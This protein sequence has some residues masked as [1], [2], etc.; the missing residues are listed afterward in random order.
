MTARAL[1]FAPSPGQRPRLF[2]FHHAGGAASVFAAWRAA[3]AADLDVLP[4]QLPGRESR[5][6]EPL[7][8]DLGS[9]VTT[10][11]A[12][13]GPHLRPP[14]ALYGH[15]L[16][17][18]VAY[19]LARRRLSQG[20]APPT[21]LLVGACPAPHLRSG[22]QTAHEAGE[23][24]LVAAMRRI[25]GLSAEVLRYPEWLRAATDLLRGD[26]R[27]MA[28][29]RAPDHEPLPVP[30]HAFHGSGDPLV[31]ER[32]MAAW[33][34]WTTAGFTRHHVAGGHFF[35]RD[36]GPEFFRTLADVLSPSPEFSLT[37][38]ERDT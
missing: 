25:G 13:L 2:C 12:D 33:A 3:L 17:G 1:P 4:V 21:A 36:P 9:L 6:R 11:D 18:A 31:S 27:M 24:E 37:T 10:L 38:V 16:G 5:R 34:G 19:Q 29:E 8:L 23:E 15:S 35:F 26:L 20:A 14:Y 30:L 22:L 7:P 32:Q 28:A